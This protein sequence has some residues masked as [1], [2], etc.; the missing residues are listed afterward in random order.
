MKLFEIKDVKP[1]KGT[2]AGVR[3]SDTTKKAIKKY[4]DDN[5]I[6]NAI[7]PNKLHTTLLYSRKYLPKYT[8]EG[9]YKKLMTGVPGKFD[10]WKS[11]PDDGSKPKN[12]LIVEYTCPQLDER[13]NELMK[14]HGG[15]YDYP[16][17]KTH[18]TLSYDIGDMKIKDLPDFKDTCPVIQIVS[19]YGEDLDLNW[20]NNKG[21]K[22]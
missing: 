15:T 20:A 4:M 11:K 13:H 3:F 2:Y 14:K 17:Y 18:L 9:E 7:A 12:C 19:E 6:P 1:T 8:P 21:T 16:E 5:K 22:K 10:V